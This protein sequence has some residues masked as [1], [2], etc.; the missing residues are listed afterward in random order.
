[1]ALTKEQEEQIKNHLLS[2]LDNF[3]EDKRI[4]IKS[5]IE[6]MTPQD[7]ENFVQ[8]NQLT[9]LGGQCIMCSILSGQQ[10]SYLLA[11]N[12]DNTAI[13]EINPLSKGH[14]L[15]LPNDHTSS[16]TDSTRKLGEDISSRLKE[17]FS[18]K[19]IKSNELEIMGHKVLEIIPLYGDET[20][21]SQVSEEELERLK[22]EI[23]KPSKKTQEVVEEIKKKE[24]ISKYKARLP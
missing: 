21:R 9:H 20:K 2:Q 12:K 3:P 24:E 6:S 14:A 19:E 7:L 13:L 17:K 18:T 16:I 11:Q 4:Q 22:E 8:Q 23:L 10:K 1:M 5:Q 15:I